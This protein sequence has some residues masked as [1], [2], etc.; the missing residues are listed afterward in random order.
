[1]APKFP[2]GYGPEGED[3]VGGCE[4]FFIDLNPIYVL[5]KLELGTYAN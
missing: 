5:V 4:I 3:R 2:C 1:M